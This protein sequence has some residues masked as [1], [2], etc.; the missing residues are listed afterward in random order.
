MSLPIA[1]LRIIVITGQAFNLLERDLRCLIVSMRSDSFYIY[2]MRVRKEPHSLIM[3]YWT[4]F[5]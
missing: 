2:Y 4:A 1:F 3:L 5:L